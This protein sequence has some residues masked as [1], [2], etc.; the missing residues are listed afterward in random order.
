MPSLR[1]RA[2]GLTG[3]QLRNPA[4]TGGVPPAGLPPAS[5]PALPPVMPE[6]L[7][8]NSMMLTSLPAVSTTLDGATR[9]FFRGVNLPVRRVSLPR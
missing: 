6:H 4:T 2:T 3:Y 7:V 9:Q 1:S 5:H 8:A